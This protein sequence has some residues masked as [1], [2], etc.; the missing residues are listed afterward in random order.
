MY[1]AKVFPSCEKQQKKGI[2]VEDYHVYVSVVIFSGD[3]EV[4]LKSRKSGQE[5]LI[6]R[7]SIFLLVKN[8]CYDIIVSHKNGDYDMKIM[9]I[10]DKYISLISETSSVFNDI[11]DAQIGN[12]VVT[13]EIAPEDLYL[14]Y[15]TINKWSDKSLEDRDISIFDI[16]YVLSFFRND[17]KVITALRLCQI[18]TTA[19]KVVKIMEK[20][21]SKNWKINEVSEQLFITES[22][23]RKKLQNENLSFRKLA[24]DVKMKHASIYLRRSNKQ[25]SQIARILGFNSTSYFIKVFREYYNITPKKYIKFFRN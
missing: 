4:R 3:N 12:E 15:Q 16:S 5:V 22:C 2:T 23:L 7:N 10:P 17:I 9:Y 19:S 11:Q 21:L 6:G 18:E 1:F 13:K 14:F 8:S 25:I 20:K 24:V